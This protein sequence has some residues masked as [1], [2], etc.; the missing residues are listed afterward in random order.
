MSG[1]I[2]WNHRRAGRVVEKA[3]DDGHHVSQWSDAKERIIGAGKR[4]FVGK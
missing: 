1:W 4:I 2:E 3:D